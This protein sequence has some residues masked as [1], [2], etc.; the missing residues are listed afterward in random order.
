MPGKM[1]TVTRLPAIAMLCAAAALAQDAA[2]EPLLLTA[3]SARA[4]YHTTRRVTERDPLAPAADFCIIV[5]E[6]T[7]FKLSCT[8]RPTSD[9]GSGRRYYYSI[10]LFQDLDQAAYLAACS[11]TV[12]D[13]LCGELA[14]GQ[15]FSAEVQDR[16]IRIVTRGQQLPL[17]I[18][19]RRPPPVSI[20]SPTRGT[21]SEVKPATGTPSQV[22]YSNAPPAQGTPSNIRPSE[23]PRSGGTPSNLPISQVS[24][25]V[26]S[27]GAAKLYLYCDNGLAQVF[28]DDQ[29][30]GNA[31]LETPIVPGRHT[32][33]V[34]ADGFEDWIRRI[35]FTAGQTTRL[36]AKLEK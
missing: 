27:P 30:M 20:D 17:R 4:A 32:V 13:S 21:P 33:I 31:P 6:Q 14:E 24:T 15:T 11:S 34:K 1:N 9:R 36:T 35:D 19:E 10:V 29:P 5:P 26:A 16:A 25:A 23:A 22:P 2:P 7:S 28:V 3:V 12:R 18:L 8:S